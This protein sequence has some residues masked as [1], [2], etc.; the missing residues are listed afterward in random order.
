MAVDVGVAD[1][2]LCGDLVV[3]VARE[4]QGEEGARSVGEPG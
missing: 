1:A 2:E 4:L 3:A